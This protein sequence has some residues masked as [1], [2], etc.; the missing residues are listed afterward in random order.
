MNRKAWQATVHGV[1]KSR[2][3]LSGQHTFKAGDLPKPGIDPGSPA[4]Q[5]DSLPSEPTGKYLVKSPQ[6]KNR[7]KQMLSLKY[8]PYFP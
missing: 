8:L 1:A 5:A 2:T 3:R 6:G 7:Q 4:L